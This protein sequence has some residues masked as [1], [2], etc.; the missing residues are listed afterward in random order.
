MKLKIE[1]ISD[2]IC[3]WCFIGK[4]RLEKA[5]QMLGDD[6]HPEITWLP[7]Q[8]NPEMPADGMDRDSYRTAK[9]GSWE[10]SQRLDAEIRRV[11][12]A[13]GISFA[14]EKMRRTPNTLLAHR[15]LWLARQHGLPD[16]LAEALFSAYFIEG[17]DVGNSAA[18]ARI[19]SGAGIAEEQA[20]NFLAGSEGA[21]ELRVEE[22]RA[23]RLG[24]S[25]VPFFVIDSRYSVS[26]A[27][28]PAVM[29]PALKAALGGCSPT[30]SGGDSCAL[31]EGPC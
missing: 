15:L 19:A 5:L 29:L 24:V 3:P 1:I 11:G 27:Q 21:A 8:L 4:R 17:L 12:A 18:L 25:G 30:Q 26:G 28:P 16:A 22:E 2:V 20:R 23:R 13:E 31:A 14:F 7:Y 10:K 9:F 6:V